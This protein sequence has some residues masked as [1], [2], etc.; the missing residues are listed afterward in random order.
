MDGGEF[1]REW[2]VAV[3]WYVLVCVCRFAIDVEVER[4]ILVADDSPIQHRYPPLLLHFLGP[5]NVWMD[6]VEVVMKRL[7]MIIANG[8]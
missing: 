6:G 7:D 3:K 4:P 2:L 8:C 1:M 5:L